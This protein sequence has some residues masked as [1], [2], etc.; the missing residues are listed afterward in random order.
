MVIWWF[1][2]KEEADNSSHLG[3]YLFGEF[4]LMDFLSFRHHESK[5]GKLL[6]GVGSETYNRPRAGDVY[7]FEM[8]WERKN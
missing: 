8:G 1:S 6:D 7:D 3:V 4:P 5:M 2:E